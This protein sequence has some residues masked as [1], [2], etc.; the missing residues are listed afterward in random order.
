MLHIQV[1][2]IYL[3]GQFVGSYVGY[4]LVRAVIPDE[5]LSNPQEFCLAKPNSD[6]VKA[7][8]IE[9]IVC[10]VTIL[11]LCSVWHPKNAQHHGRFQKIKFLY[12]LNFLFLNRQ[13][14]NKIRPLGYPH[15]IN[16]CKN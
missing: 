8:G 11:F 3:L 9:F 10:F 14:F 6:N 4:A 12:F 5:Y 13:C 7:F 1:A 2:L 16:S 15:R